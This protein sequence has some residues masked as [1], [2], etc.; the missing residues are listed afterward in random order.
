VRSGRI[1]FTI[2]RGGSNNFYRGE[3]PRTHPFTGKGHSMK[4]VIRLFCVVFILAGALAGNQVGPTLKAAVLNDPSVSA[5]PVSDEEIPPPPGLVMDCPTIDFENLAI[6]TAVTTQY[7]GV[8]FSVRPQSC[9]SKPFLYMRIAAAPAGGTSSGTQVLKIDDGCEFSPDYLCMNFDSTQQEIR[10]GLGMQTGAAG[11]PF[12]VRAYSDSGL[13]SKTTY[14]CGGGVRTF[15]QVSDAN[16]RI[17][18]VEVES[19]TTMWELIDD[20]QFTVDATPPIAEIVQPTQGACF[21]NGDAVTGRAYDA[22]KDIA[23]W[24]LEWRSVLADSDAAWKLLG[25]GLTEVVNGELAH[26]NSGEPDGQYNL[27][28][29]VNNLCGLTDSAMTQV[30]LDRTFGS[31]RLSKPTEGAVLG[32]TVCIDGTV[33][34]TCLANYSVKYKPHDG[35]TWSPVDPGHG[36]YTESVTNDPLAS[37]ETCALADG[38]YEVK[39][40]AV[41][42]CGNTASKVVAVTLDNT[43]PTAVITDPVGCTDTGGLIVISGTANDTNLA[44][45]ELHYTGTGLGWIPLGRGDVPVISGVLGEWDTRCLPACAYTLRL[46]VTDKALIDCSTNGHVTEYLVSVNVGL[47]ADLDRDGKVDLED[48]ALFARQWLMEY[49]SGED[50]VPIPGGMFEMGD[51]TEEGEID[52]IP[53]HS[54]TVDPFLMGRYEVTNRQYCEFLNDSLAAGQV[55]VRNDGEV[56]AVGTWTAYLSLTSA[57]SSSRISFDGLAFSIVPGKETHPVLHV[58]W[59]G[60]AAYCNWK[61]RMHGLQE[62]YDPA[63]WD[64]TLNAGGYRLPTEAEWE[65][66]A[67]GGLSGKRYPWGD[68]IVPSQANYIDSGDPYE[69]G[70]GPGTTPVGF[71]NGQLRHKADYNWPGSDATY[72]T[73]SGINGYGLHDMAG[74]NLEWCNDWY[75]HDY[76]SI[77]PSDNPEGPSSSIWRV[78]RGG[79]WYWTADDC[80]VACRRCSEPGTRY[81]HFGFRVVLDLN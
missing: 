54:V 9:S 76:Y 25:F 47:G 45:W 77:S 4:T 56:Y 12:S 66:A 70:D 28:L 10:F 58:T 3:S 75:W 17:R 24:I 23:N 19:T 46:R 40:E 79:D 44:S 62:C 78:L 72:Q 49:C 48:F 13:L 15:V 5:E 18:R 39:V 7:P 37:W 73:T 34:D 57:I 65:Y 61:S 74:N 53:L 16:G 29:T 27:R 14:T 32:G 68:T 30:L 1:Q 31:L 42:R 55:V 51:S 38:T 80:R 71:Y 6:G 81:S 35:D 60:S 21:C 43:P 59:F 33:S 63:T 2:P 20:L 22:D 11:Y 41:D 67:R 36:I 50:M 64:C 26:W 69:D 52:E 8:T